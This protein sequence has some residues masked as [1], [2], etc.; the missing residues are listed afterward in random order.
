MTCQS[1]WNV[2]RLVYRSSA[3]TVSLSPSAA[4]IPGVRG[5]PDLQGDIRSV[6]SATGTSLRI[7]KAG[8][9]CDKTTTGWYDASSSNFS[10]DQ[11]RAK[12]FFDR[13]DAGS[14]AQ[15]LWRMYPRLAQEIEVYLLLFSR[16]LSSPDP[17]AVTVLLSSERWPPDDR[18]RRYSLR[19]LAARAATAQRAGSEVTLR[20]LRPDNAL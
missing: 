2:G 11:R 19:P 4:A 14:V 18:S 17:T 1:D 12:L 20:T 15:Q 3:S 13:L 10:T 8:A 16:H 7:G 5:L 9:V 6:R